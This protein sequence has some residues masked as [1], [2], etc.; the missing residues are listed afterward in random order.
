VSAKADPNDRE[1]ARGSPAPFRQED[2]ERLAAGEMPDDIVTVILESGISPGKAAPITKGKK[3]APVELTA[4]EID[5]LA[6][7]ES[8]S[9][10]MA[11]RLET[12]AKLDM[13]R[14][15]AAGTRAERPD[16]TPPGE[17][18]TKR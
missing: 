2:I 14:K 18:R 9:E 1:G 5:A 17:K 8:T 7:G 11:E 12:A 4:K 10:E 6:R 3:L 15:R 16:I 13:N